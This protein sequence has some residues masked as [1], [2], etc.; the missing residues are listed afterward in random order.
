VV[1]YFVWFVD[2]FLENVVSF[3][4]DWV[5]GDLDWWD[6]WIPIL[7]CGLPLVFAIWLGVWAF[8]SRGETEEERLE[9][10]RGKRLRGVL[11][12]PD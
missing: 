7:F 9:K 6:A 3:V 11:G 12:I 5:R 10:L 8:L 2:S 1:V 4:Q